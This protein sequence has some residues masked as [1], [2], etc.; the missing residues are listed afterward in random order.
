[1]HER[2]RYRELVFGSSRLEGFG[3][4]KGDIVIVREFL[5]AP[6]LKVENWLADGD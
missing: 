4:R 6:G 2:V 3:F 1:M 5:R